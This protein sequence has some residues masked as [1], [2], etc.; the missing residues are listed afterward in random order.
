MLS[1]INTNT[2]A[3]NLQ[4]LCFQKGIKWNEKVLTLS[5]KNI[6]MFLENGTTDV[7]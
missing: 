2:T 3:T 1:F 4:G 6:Q 5:I 7:M